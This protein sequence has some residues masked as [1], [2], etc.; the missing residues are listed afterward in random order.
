MPH[1]NDICD[2]CLS[3]IISGS[4]H[5]ATDGSIAFF[6]MTEYHSTVYMVHF[7]FIH[8]TQILLNITI[9]VVV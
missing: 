2:I 4:I 8:L 7:L 9:I 3:Q 1:I 6:F 5:I